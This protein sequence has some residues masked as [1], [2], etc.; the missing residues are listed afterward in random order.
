MN[1]SGNYRLANKYLETIFHENID[2][3][4]TIN[5]A[6][7][8]YAKSLIK[9]SPDLTSEELFFHAEKSF[10]L[11]RSE[12]KDDTYFRIM[13]NYVIESIHLGY[14]QSIDIID[15][16]VLE[17]DQKYQY[18]HLKLELQKIWLTWRMYPEDVIDFERIQSKMTLQNYTKDQLEE[19]EGIYGRIKKEWLFHNEKYLEFEQ[20][21]LHRLY[22][23]KWSGKPLSPPKS[24]LARL[25]RAQGKYEEALEIFTKEQPN[26]VVLDI[27]SAGEQNQ[28]NISAYSF[29]NALVDK[30]K[31]A[32]FAKNLKQI[33]KHLDSIV[34]DEEILITQGAG[35]IVDISN[36]IRAI[37]K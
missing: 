18:W 16:I 10:Q 29:V 22:L 14:Q 12:E 33:C 31:N 25:Y 2:S 6:F 17:L 8:H 9:K 35:N 11:Y 7:A 28:E 21:A 4:S 32:F 24:D 37:Y 30:G 1:R 27:Y 15:N 23:F 36:S 5:L 3:Q 26:L 20:L 34:G 19:L 13:Y